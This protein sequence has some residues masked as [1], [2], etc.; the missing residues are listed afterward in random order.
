MEKISKHVSYKEGVKS[1][2]ATRLGIDN[3]PTAYQLS[4]MDRDW[5]TC[6]LIFSMHYIPFM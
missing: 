2:T 3:T 4:N 1:N 6:L 5:E